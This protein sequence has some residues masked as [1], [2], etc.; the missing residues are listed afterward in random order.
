MLG[1]ARPDQMAE[2]RAHPFSV[3]GTAGTSPSGAWHALLS[4]RHN[5]AHCTEHQQLPDRLLSLALLPLH[6]VDQYNA[7]VPRL[8]EVTPDVDASPSAEAAMT[9]H[10]DPD[11]LTGDSS[12]TE[13]EPACQPSTA[14]A[15]SAENEQQQQQQW[16]Q[17]RQRQ[18]QE[19]EQEQEYVENQPQ[20][21][22]LLQYQQQPQLSSSPSPASESVTISHGTAQQVDAA[23]AE[24]EEDADAEQDEDGEGGQQAAAGGSELGQPSADGQCFD[25]DAPMQAAPEEEQDAAAVMQQQQEEDGE[26]AEVPSS[27]NPPMPTAESDRDAPTDTGEGD[28]ARLGQSQAEPVEAMEHDGTASH[29]AVSSDDAAAS[30]QAPELDATCAGDVKVEAPPTAPAP[31]PSAVAAPPAAESGAAPVGVASLSPR[32][33]PMVVPPCLS[34]L[35]R[36][37]VSPIGHGSSSQSFAQ[38]DA[39]PPPI[40]AASSALAAP[41]SAASCPAA[42]DSTA[43]ALVPQQQQQQQQQQPPPMP[44]QQ[45]QAPPAQ[46]PPA[47]QPPPQV[48]QQ[49]SDDAGDV[50][51]LLL[52]FGARATSLP[53]PIPRAP[54]PPQAGA[55]LLYQ[56]SPGGTNHAET[57]GA[58]Q[59]GPP[60][61]A[62]AP[63]PPGDNGDG[64]E[65]DE[66]EAETADRHGDA[67]D[68]SYGSRGQRVTDGAVR[69]RPHAA[70]AG[71]ADGGEATVAINLHGVSSK[72]AIGARIQVAYMERQGKM[73]VSVPYRGSVVSIDLKRGLRVKLDGYT[74]REW[75]TDED[76]W[77]WLPEH[78]SAPLPHQLELMAQH[79]ASEDG[80]GAG[81][82]PYG[83]GG[84]NGAP[85]GGKSGGKS[86]GKQSVGAGCSATSTASSNTSKGPAA[87]SKAQPSAGVSYGGKSS[88]GSSGGPTPMFIAASLV[89]LRLRGVGNV[90]L[91]RSLTDKPKRS[92]GVRAL[93]YSLQGAAMEFKDELYDKEIAEEKARARKAKPEPKDR[94]A[95]VGGAGSSSSSVAADGG[96]AGISNGGALGKAREAPMRR[97]RR[98]RLAAAKRAWQTRRRPTARTTPLVAVPPAAAAAASMSR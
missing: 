64:D 42:C 84:A 77:G 9:L 61:F 50:A 49:P 26:R 59:H 18:V 29:P 31:P 13:H 98:A 74:R 56:L 46:P 15:E 22:Q 37:P 28:G 8:Q 71:A 14:P 12:S 43:S 70:L 53:P 2:V 76:E 82:A 57:V 97:R 38:R 91:P 86:G 62:R 40:G 66:D 67:P 33:V 36:G 23:G 39:P 45:Q 60:R 52:G 63:L 51:A 10:A 55:E 83:A 95:L 93:P 72:A 3:L 90:E 48:Q 7:S 85:V 94:G 78:D 6:T 54:T 47:Q 35:A 65:E 5:L 58:A 17:Q 27:A 80:G 24:A 81:R 88:S 68:D 19:Q 92:A 87:A 32:G 89:R 79:T 21:L 16:Q 96:D 4:S 34:H 30:S 44:L 1:G 11:A 73:L 69:S 25:S 75:V 41:P 20:Q